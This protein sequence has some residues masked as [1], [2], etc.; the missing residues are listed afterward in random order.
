MSK[1]SKLLA[2]ALLLVT[3][4]VLGWI[5]WSRYTELGIFAGGG[6]RYWVRRAAVATTDEEAKAHLGRVLATTQYGVN[7]AENAVADLPD[8]EARLRMWRLLVE[9]APNDN[10]RSIYTRRLKTEGNQPSAPSGV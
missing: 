1:P 2:S 6:G 5:P 8:H 9:L 7:I 4:M 3:L 10:W